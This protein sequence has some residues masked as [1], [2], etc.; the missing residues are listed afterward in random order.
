MLQRR[1]DYGEFHHLVQ[2]LPFHPDKFKQYFR[3]TEEQF[4][5]IAE[6]IEDDIKK[7]DTN[8]KQAISPKERLSICLR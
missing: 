8:W 2:E 1:H 4:D 3:M 6:L 5:Y 7:Q